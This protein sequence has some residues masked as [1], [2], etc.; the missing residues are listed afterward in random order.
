M[1]LSHF[2]VITHRDVVSRG[3]IL[4]TQMSKMKQMYRL[5]SEEF[6]RETR[7]KAS[8]KA[9][10]LIMLLQDVHIRSVSKMLS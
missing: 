7:R 5:Q 1:T 6:G 2:N 9:V 3:N 8:F 4:S 10:K